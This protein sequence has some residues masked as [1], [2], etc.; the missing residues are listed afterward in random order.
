MSARTSIHINDKEN[1]LAIFR[2][3]KHIKV[4]DTPETAQDDNTIQNE[5]DGD[6][7]GTISQKKRSRS[8]SA[9]SSSNISNCS[10]NNS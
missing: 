1:D 7:G 10:F 9:Q 8:K 6:T 4:K 5:E 3:P 2:R